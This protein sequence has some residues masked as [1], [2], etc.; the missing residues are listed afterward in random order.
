MSEGILK[1]LMQL[2]ALIAFPQKDNESRRLIVK[3]FLGQQLNKT[4][5]EEYL[6]IYESHYQDHA[7]KLKKLQ[8][9]ET[10]R[11]TLSANSV[12]ALRISHAINKELTHYQK[13]IVIIRLIEFLKSGVEIS[14]FER[15]FVS[16]IA[17]T[18]HI[19]DA[20]YTLM[21]HFVISD[22]KLTID[23]RNVLIIN[24]KPENER[25][26]ARHLVWD[27]VKNE[28]KILRIKSAGL[29]LLKTD[30]TIDIS[31]NGQLL[32]PNR[33]HVL[34]PGCSIRTKRSN[35]IYY[36]D[37]VGTYT[38]DNITTPIHFTAQNISYRFNNK[39]MGVQTMSLSSQ[40]GKLVGIM[41]TSGAGKTT[42]TNILS[43]IYTP[44]TGKVLINGVDIHNSN[45][46]DGLI[47]Y[48]SQ[49]DLLME[50]L[51]VY[52]N[53]LYNAKL[54]FGD[55]S[56]FKIQRRVLNLLNSLGLAEIKDMKVGSPLNK[57]IS[58]G[59]RKR[60]NI[61]LELIREPAVLFLDEPTSGL[62]SRDSD[63]I[64][65]LLKE[66]AQKGKL[67]FIVIHQPS[68]DIFKMFNQLLVLDEGGYLIYDGN[69]VESITY[70]KSSVK[71]ANRQES[72]CNTCGNVNPEQVLN[73]ITSQVIDE[74]GSFTHNRK[75]AP[76]EWHERFKAD[77]KP[78][79]P[80]VEKSAVELPKINFKVPNKFKQ[81]MVFVKR[82]ILS[83]L[84]NRQ[85]LLINL[86]ETPV[87]A[88]LLSSII[89]YYNVN[90]LNDQG[91]VFQNNPNVV[92]YIIMLVI[93]AIF[94]GL[95]VSA[96]EIISDRKILKREAFL[97]LSRFSYLLSKVFILII[98]S[99][100]QTF[101]LV[102]IGN[103]II[104]IKGMFFEYWLIL[105]SVSIF[106]N[107]LGLNISD[108]F[109]QAV[110]IYILIPF[111]I[112]P[113]IIL[114]GVFISY[115]NLNPSYTKPDSIPW[116]GEIITARWAFE[117]LAVHQFTENDFEK[118]FY[119][120]DKIKSVAHFKKEYWVPALE[121]K[122]EYCR[123]KIRSN[124]SL[125]DANNQLMDGLALLKNEIIAEN[126]S[127]LI[128]QDIPFVEKLSPAKFN[129]AAYRDVKSYLKEKKSTYR[130][131]FNSTDESLDRRKKKMT[132][133]NANR[134]SLNQLKRDYFNLELE[135]YVRNSNHIFSDKIIEYKGRLVQ[136]SDPIFKEPESKW[137]KAHFL[138]PYKRF[139]TLQ[140]NTLWANLIV[141]W[142]FN[143]FL[144]FTLQSAL[145]K[146]LMGQMSGLYQLLKRNGGNE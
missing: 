127:A 7:S 109:K 10:S 60:L 124:E 143:L 105:F 116:F 130:R 9:T 26:N 114:S 82:D 15:D 134:D 3:N 126:K 13:L 113:Q 123:N 38:H 85:Y 51:T 22:H 119:L 90:A 34:T 4:M 16:T 57:K 141:I 145:L 131:L 30:D 6:A 12:K 91:Y 39:T 54:C 120:Y 53:L 139:G 121:A 140:I 115:D 92:I 31:I 69:P 47:G 88:L 132:G 107:L 27:Y 62:S 75:I 83:K 77:K 146:K 81:F 17:Q 102:I 40:S 21:E 142:L 20:E 24:N 128:K 61:A 112:I 23:N 1:A 11:T 87:L 42:L 78:V 33:I 58:G 36:S 136:K 18:F 129:E 99:A 104:E 70:F 32:S 67:I 110:N 37:I 71:Q 84:S 43:G 2:F 59:Q 118:Q 133:S 46:T 52:Q 138:S 14:T 125:K 95:T 97:N 63:N 108:S 122:L 19:N 80:T 56:E 35:P 64:I 8:Q 29:Y 103:S 44:Y 49:D 45:K 41:G 93:I 50:N 74:Y 5:V 101:L 28:I 65:D 76:T 117:A 72:E 55:Y 79:N 48:V 98:I 135:R 25:N 144:F 68:S 94:V 96:E 66:L 73:I 106:S 86:L 137:L 89:K 111:L 100:V